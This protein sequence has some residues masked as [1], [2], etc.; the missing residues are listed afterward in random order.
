MPRAK[1]IQGRAVRKKQYRMVGTGTGKEKAI[2]QAAVKKKRAPA[3]R[4]H[5][6]QRTELVEFLMANEDRPTR[7]VVAEFREQCPH[8]FV[9]IANVVKNNRRHTYQTCR[10]CGQFATSGKAV[11]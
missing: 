5:G 1:S 3:P 4:M 9:E 11:V 6:V 8:N 10:R 2:K 7:E